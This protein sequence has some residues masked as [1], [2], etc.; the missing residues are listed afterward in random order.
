MTK[1]P[2]SLAPK[3][4]DQKKG[5]KLYPNLRHPRGSIRNSYNSRC[6]VRWFKSTWARKVWVLVRLQQLTCSHRFKHHAWHQSRVRLS[7][8]FSPVGKPTRM[9]SL[10][11]QVSSLCLDDPAFRPHFYDPSSLH[12]CLVPRTLKS[13]SYPTNWSGQSW[14]YSP[15]EHRPILPK[16]LSW[17]WRGTSASTP[18]NLMHAYASWCYPLSIRNSAKSAD[19]HLSRRHPSLPSTPSSPCCSLLVSSSESRTPWRSKNPTWKTSTSN[20]WNSFPRRLSS[21]KRSTQFRGARLKPIPKA[22]SAAWRAVRSPDAKRTAP[23][24]V[25]QINTSPPHPMDPKEC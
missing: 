24:Q 7:K 12:A 11:S 4:G 20:S 21:S 13:L 22:T 5:T 14:N 16:K 2:T 23:A 8:T 9:P 17:M 15:Q 18:P 3:G 25:Q 1:T 19:G 6:A 10:H